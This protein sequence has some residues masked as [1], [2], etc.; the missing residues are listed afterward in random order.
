MDVAKEIAALKKLGLFEQ[1]TGA[2]KVNDRLLAAQGEIAMLRRAA[3]RE[4]RRQGWTLRDLAEELDMS[5]Q[6]VLQIEKGS[7]RKK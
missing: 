7:G 6:R 3:V 5:P 1:I 2:Q 4:P